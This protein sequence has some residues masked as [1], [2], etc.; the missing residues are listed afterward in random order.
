MQVPTVSGSTTPPGGGNGFSILG[1]DDFLKLLLA[2]LKNQ[3]PMKP[4]DD[5]QF[6][7][8]LAQFTAVE[9]M[10]QMSDQTALLLQVEQLGQASNLLGKEVEALTQTGDK[11]SGVV[12][13]M[14]MVDGAAVL[15][16]GNQQIKLADVIS[17]TKT[18]P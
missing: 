12:D 7:A 18:S 13:T 11:V 3:D 8:Q 6:V 17:V 14:K 9:K 16:V 15:M 2:Q 5:T 1:K 10:Q 4:M